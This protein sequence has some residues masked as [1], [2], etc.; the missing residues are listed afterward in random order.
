MGDVGWRVTV[1]TAILLCALLAIGIIIGQT[2][3]ALSPEQITERLVTSEGQA[4][5]HHY[6]PATDSRPVA[7]LSVG[8]KTKPPVVLVHS[9][10]GAAD[11]WIDLITSTDILTFAWIIAVDR[12]GFSGSQ[13]GVHQANL[14]LQAKAISQA[15]KPLLAGRPAVWLG[16]Q[17]WRAGYRSDRYGPS[18][19]G[20]RACFCCCIGRSGT[21]D[22][23][24]YQQAAD[25]LCQLGLAT[26]HPD[27]QPRNSTTALRIISNAATMA[28]FKTNPCSIVHGTNDS[29]VPVDNA[30]FIKTIYLMRQYIKLSVKDTFCRGDRHRS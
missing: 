19:P 24:W 12:P 16:Q 4:I 28:K 18:A 9:S 30:D 8:D 1:T 22:R 13:P 23:Q 27:H 3:P 11:N 21:R 25:L 15:V 26:S 14:A 6:W 17:L 7:C 29:L 20:Q 10:P 2:I 5:P